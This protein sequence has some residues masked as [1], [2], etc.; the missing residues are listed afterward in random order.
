M[1]KMPLFVTTVWYSALRLVS[2][3]VSGDQKLPNHWLTGSQP[4]SWYSKPIPKSF[5][6]TTPSKIMC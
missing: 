5:E 4:E 1:H 6:P 3:I 2:K